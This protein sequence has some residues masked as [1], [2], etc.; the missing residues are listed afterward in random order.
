MKLSISFVLFLVSCVSSFASTWTFHACKDNY[1]SIRVVDTWDWIDVW[2]C[3]WDLAFDSNPSNT[4]DSGIS[5]YDGS[6]FTEYSGYLDTLTVE[7]P[8]YSDV[9]WFGISGPYPDYSGTVGSMFPETRNSFPVPGEYWIDF[10][11]DNCGFRVTTSK[12]SDFG[13]WSWNGSVN[14]SWIEPAPL[15]GKGR[16][17]NR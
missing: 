13:K 10:Y 14:P 6:T 8:Q 5:F 4:P 2:H 15:K 9:W 7:A 1:T 17:K 11:P 12:P 3:Q 16:I